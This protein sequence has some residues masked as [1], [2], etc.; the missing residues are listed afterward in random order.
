MVHL[1]SGVAAIDWRWVWLVTAAFLAGLLNA[2]A[3]GGS[4]LLFPA[5]MGTGM[6]P[7]Q[8]NATNTVALWPGQFASVAAYWT[9]IRK[10]LR[11]AVPMALAGLAGGSVGAVV[12]LATPQ[13]TFLHLVPWLL[14]V[15]ASIF[16]VSGP[17]TRQLERWKARRRERVERP[18]REPHVVAVFFATMLICFYIGYFGAG[19]GFLII[20]LMSLFG[21]EDL[22]RINGLKVAATTPANGIAFVIFVVR[23]QVL[24]RYCLAAM[25]VCAV[26]GYSSARLARRV[27]QPV[28]RAVVVI[29][30]LSMAAWFFWRNS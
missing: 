14:L 5:M 9:I 25:V 26:G 4:F 19:A 23:G 13:M 28:L 3:G 12:L 10:N 1:F 18:R 7:V 11:L 29:I 8:A 16:A 15:A 27:R 24:W 2:V 30:G 6:L 17:L 20:T 21:L 22:H